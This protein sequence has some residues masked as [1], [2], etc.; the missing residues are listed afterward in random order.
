MLTSRSGQFPGRGTIPV[1]LTT[2]SQ[3]RTGMF[4]LRPI[5][6]RKF[7]NFGA[8]PLKTETCANAAC[9][10]LLHRAHKG[11]QCPGNKWAASLHKRGGILQPGGHALAGTSP[12]TYFCQ[13]TGHNLEATHCCKQTQ[14]VHKNKGNWMHGQALEIPWSFI[15]WVM[16]RLQNRLSTSGKY[17]IP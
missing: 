13:P 16:S 11:A 10:D 3:P 1:Y 5:W 6:H 17:Q 4:F 2:P 9:Q 14:A 15:W 12:G 8:F 7:I